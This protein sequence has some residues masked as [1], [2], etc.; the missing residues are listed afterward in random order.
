MRFDDVLA[1]LRGVHLANI[2]NVLAPGTQRVRELLRAP[3]SISSGFRSEALNAA[4]GNSLRRQRSLGLAD[5]GMW[6][7][8][9]FSPKLRG[10]VLR[11]KFTPLGAVYSA[12]LSG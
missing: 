3:V 8:I 11:A 9:S 2:R 1:A 12:G 4:I 7:H 5:E 6:K 10:V